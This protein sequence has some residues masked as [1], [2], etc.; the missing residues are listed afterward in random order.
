[1]LEISK[2]KKGDEF[3]DGFGRH[4][5]KFI[6]IDGRTVY[7]NFEGE[8]VEIDIV[9]SGL[10]MNGKLFLKEITLDVA[11]G[12]YLYED[13]RKE[14][15]VLVKTKHKDVPKDS[16]FCTFRTDKKTLLPCLEKFSEYS[17][18]GTERGQLEDGK[19]INTFLYVVKDK[20]FIAAENKRIEKLIAFQN[21]EHLQIVVDYKEK[22]LLKLRADLANAEDVLRKLE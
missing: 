5:L 16:W 7:A 22:E 1:M 11:I 2:L 21:V 18:S 8:T 4:T 20:K 6:K 13:R 10:E 17:L 15:L 3:S 19:E 9:S 14:T 12:A